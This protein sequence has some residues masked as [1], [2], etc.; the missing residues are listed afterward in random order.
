MFVEECG[1]V[2]VCFVKVSVSG[3][4]RSYY[5]VST[6]GRGM[7][8]GIVV[9]GGGTNFGRLLAVVRSLTGPT[10]V[11]VKFRSATRCTLGLRLFLRG[12]LLAF[13]RMGPILVD[14]CGG[15]GALEH[16]GASS[17]SYRSVTH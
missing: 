2:S 6:T 7:I 13:V 15:S 17:I 12:S 8:S 5:V 11:E 10:S 3:C 16:A 4:G 9:G 1:P 14:R